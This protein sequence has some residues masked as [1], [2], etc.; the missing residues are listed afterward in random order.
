MFEPRRV[1]RT[2]FVATDD[3]PRR[4]RSVALGWSLTLALAAGLILGG[5]AIPFG[6]GAESTDR[7]AEETRRD[8][9]RLYL[10]EQERIE[11]ARQTFDPVPSER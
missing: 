4:A 1:C 6:A 8:R 3:R 7:S 2:P 5:C 9:N 10:E 11:R